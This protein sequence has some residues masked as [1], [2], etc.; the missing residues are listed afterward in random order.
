M[1]NILYRPEQQAYI[2]KIQCAVM[3]KEEKQAIL[4]SQ[5]LISPNIFKN[6]YGNLKRIL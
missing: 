3:P 6:I 4:A 5:A 1:R 2:K